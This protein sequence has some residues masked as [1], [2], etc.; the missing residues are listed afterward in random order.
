MKTAT[1]MPPNNLI[2]GDLHAAL[3]FFFIRTCRKSQDAVASV[4]IAHRY[5]NT[6]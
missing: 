2:E 3:P 6:L 4:A 1:R 5:G